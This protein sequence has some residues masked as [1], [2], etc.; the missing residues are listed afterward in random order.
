[1]GTPCKGSYSGAVMIVGS[2]ECV[3]N[4]FEEAKKEV[5]DFDIMAINFSGICFKGIEHLVSL[6]A[7]RIPAFL[8]A[9][10]LDNGKFIHTHSRAGKLDPLGYQIE[11]DW[12]EEIQATSGSSGLFAVRVAM[13]LG[14]KKIILCGMPL[15]S[16]RRF[17]DP[18]GAVAE[19]GDGPTF[20]GWKLAKDRGEF[21]GVEIISM[22]G[23]TKELFN[24]KNN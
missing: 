23:R 4:D 19:V 14:Y 24:V 1:M 8:M 7:D 11:N 9:A 5:K 3:F 2:A 13:K 10:S 6:H 18:I 16:S 15:S 17:Y 20:L 22:S 12:T 21:K